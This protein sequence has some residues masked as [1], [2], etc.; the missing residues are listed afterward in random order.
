[1]SESEASLYLER[2]PT[3]LR[4]LR[5]VRGLKQSDLVKMVQRG[6]LPKFNQTALSRLEDGTRVVRLDEAMVLAWALECDLNDLLREPAHTNEIS[7]L[8]TRSQRVAEQYAKLTDDIA[9]LMWLKRQL[10]DTLR[11]SSSDSTPALRLRRR[12]A[13]T[14]L[15]HSTLEEAER[16]AA[17]SMAES[18]AGREHANDW[19][20][21]HGGINEV[22]RR[23]KND[24]RADAE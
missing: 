23:Y 10:A 6:G 19:I 14:I 16:M 20:E 5:E 7:W 21:S 13:Q 11:R 3:N 12:E 15:E 22:L 24:G 1:M 17:N 8:R 4:T 18:D 9:R 2:F